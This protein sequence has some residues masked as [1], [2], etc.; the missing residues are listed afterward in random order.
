MSEQKATV[1][2]FVGAHPLLLSACALIASA[3]IE[4]LQGVP[5]ALPFGH[6]LGE[7]I[8][9]LGYGIAAA[10]AFNWIIV[11]IPQRRHRERVIAAYWWSLNYLAIAGAILLASYRDSAPGD[12]YTTQTKEQLRE[13]LSE[14]DLVE[15]VTPPSSVRV[16]SGGVNYVWSDPFARSLVLRD[17]EAHGRLLSP[18]LHRLPP[19]VADAAAT[20]I[21]FPA[22]LS[23][24][25][26]ARPPGKLDAEV[27]RIWEFVRLSRDVRRVLVQQI[28]ERQ[29]TLPRILSAIPTQHAGQIR[30]EDL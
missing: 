1:E 14:V 10:F 17:V 13:F 11:D 25:P 18:F 2:R 9:N 16:S 29:I 20:L 26:I 8:R 27:E 5:E 19:E 15:A 30:P 6:E 28:P 21:N 3:T 7:I 12:N 4:L 22:R 24:D 23:L